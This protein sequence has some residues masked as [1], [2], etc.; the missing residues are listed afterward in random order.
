MS[1]R[2]GTKKVAGGGIGCLNDLLMYMVVV[3]G[4]GVLVALSLFSEDAVLIL[5]AGVLCVLIFGL[6]LLASWDD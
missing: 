4:L 1:W 2:R 3:P 6:W 5:G